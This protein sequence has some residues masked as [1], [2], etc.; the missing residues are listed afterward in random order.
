MDWQPTPIFLPGELQDWEAWRAKAQGV[1]RSQTRLS[2]ALLLWWLLILCPLPTHSHTERPSSYVP[3]CMQKSLGQ[4]L[5]H[6]SK[7][8]TFYW[9]NKWLPNPAPQML[10][11]PWLSPTFTVSIFQTWIYPTLI[12]SAS[13][14]VASAA[15]ISW[16]K[17][18]RPAKE[19][20]H[21]ITLLNSCVT[22]LMTNN[23]RG[24]PRWLRGK[25]PTCQ[26]GDRGSV[27]GSRRSPGEGNGNPLQ[28][29]CLEN[30]MDRGAGWA[31][32][33]GVAK[34]LD[35]TSQ[36]SNDLCIYLMLPP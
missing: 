35:T 5:A 10:L 21:K 12:F 25:E 1:A 19:I 34:E 17:S 36:L 15:E 32:V 29:C 33:H 26:A 22:L 27:P 14:A 18:E 3:W 24:L 8:E 13:D 30:P 20:L 9:V 16:R 23:L 7:S 6:A 11:P 2:A 31:T 28:C 4:C